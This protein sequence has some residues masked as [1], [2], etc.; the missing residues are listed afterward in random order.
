MGLEVRSGAFWGW[1][2]GTYEME[3]IRVH[4]VL[5]A[6]DVLLGGFKLLSTLVGTVLPGCDSFSVVHQ[7]TLLPGPAILV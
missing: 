2:G 3:P 4:L 6:E 1:A 5:V 7:P